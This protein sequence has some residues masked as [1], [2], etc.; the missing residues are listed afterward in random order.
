MK[1]SQPKTCTIQ[2]MIFFFFLALCCEFPWI[3]VFRFSLRLKKQEKK[4]DL[5]LASEHFS[6][7]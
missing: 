5:A 2:S 3:K 1:N 7:S 6:A 4:G